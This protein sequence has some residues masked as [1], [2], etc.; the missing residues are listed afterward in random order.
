MVK[1]KHWLA[2]SKAPLS[3]SPGAVRFPVN[4]ATAHLDMDMDMTIRVRHGLLPLVLGLSALGSATANAQTVVGHVVEE[5]TLR[6]LLAAFVVLEDEHGARHGGVLTGVDGRFVI[7]APQ[8]GAYRVRTEM[9]GYAS[10]AS[11]LFRLEPGE[12]QERTIEVP[13]QA[14]TL[15]GIQVSGAA[16]CRPRPGS[17]PETARLWEEARKALEVTSWSERAGAMRFQGVRH[18]RVLHPGTLRVM[19]YAER[20]WR[21]WSGRSPYLSIPVDEL[22]RYGYVNEDASGDLVYHAP[23]A[24]V[25]LS[26]L[27][28]DGHCFAVVPS[29][30]D[31]PDLVGL[32][33]EPVRD[34]RLADVRGVLWLD[35][36]TAE[37]RRL[38]F[39]YTRLPQ[40]PPSLWDVAGGRVEFERLATG[41]WIVRRWSVR[42]PVVVLREGAQT[43]RHD[44][45]AVLAAIHETGG[46]VRSVVASDGRPLAETKGATV[47]GTVT[48]LDG[49]PLAG[50]TVRVVPTEWWV[51]T[52]EDGAYRLTGLPEGR[53]EVEVDHA[54][55]DV[56]GAGPEVRS[57]DLVAGR[58]VRLPL[59]LA[60]AEGVLAE[61]CGAV[62]GTASVLLHG[63]V[64][65][66]AGVPLAGA[67]VSIR[68]PGAAQGPREVLTD[69]LGVYRV[70]TEPSEAPI[71]IAAVP[72]EHLPALR[73]EDGD[74]AVAAAGGGLVRA[75]LVVAT[76][77][78]LR[79]I[80]AQGD[81]ENA[82]LGIALDE[83]TREPVAGVMLSLLDAAGQVVRTTVSD[84]TG[85]F[86]LVY[87]GR[88][89]MFH[90]RA[91]HVGYATAQ[92]EV[93]FDRSEQLRLEV[94]MTTRAIA[95]DPIVVT[96]RRRGLL[97][98]AGFYARRD[99]GLG[100][101]V[102]V[103]EVQRTRSTQVTDLLAG[104]SN[105]RVIQVPP[106]GTDIRIAGTER[107]DSRDGGTG[108]V[109]CAPA[110]YLN[111]AMVRTAGE[112]KPEDPPLSDIISP[113]AVAAIEVFRRPSEVPAR[114]GGV[115]AACGVVLLWTRQN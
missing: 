35:R 13:L 57:V 97:A 77:T 54:D 59:A 86:R 74:T 66:S 20:G 109:Q 7:R 1:L 101:F 69:S 17:G 34:G 4:S 106:F 48:G 37:L 93:R 61:I 92:G 11:S 50:A 68:H 47:Y 56:L 41:V 102:E 105:I 16:R 45:D 70:C 38:D 49:R 83:A 40:V 29:P 75:D 5:G 99:T 63:V 110:V 82:V 52:G 9:I 42:M 21:G 14:I 108:W 58:A 91:E 78:E 89:E 18:T 107:I 104:R 53:F 65:D 32:S 113:Q 31:E 23:D 62:D 94:L 8:P 3:Q 27:F 76:P 79:A 87:P 103:E 26:E 60:T 67:V 19:D 81:W 84:P 111:G 25:L 2:V 24:E 73:P 28:L 36:G 95:L 64:T 55:L 96:E 10:T 39:K 44:D 15:D 6:P 115:G 33:F 98:D 90:V 22:E 72:G 46:E 71:Q 51:T 100:V 43:V 88:G 112:P 85:R 114:F 12:T 30:P 80:G